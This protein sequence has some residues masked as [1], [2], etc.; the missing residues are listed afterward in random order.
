VN[1]DVA[2]RARGLSKI[3]KIYRHPGDVL[4]ELLTRR[5]RHEEKAAL[6]DV[7]FELRRGEVVGILGRNGAGKSTLLKL[8]A[9]TLE[10][11][12]GNLD[13]NGRITAILELG[14]GFHPDYTGRENVHMG[15]LCLGMSRDEVARK[16]DSIVDFSELAD[17]IDQPFRTY[18]TGMQARLTFSTAIAVDPDILIVD[19][20]LSVGDAKFQMKCFGRISEL[21]QQRK[22]ILLVSHDL[23]TVTSFCDHAIVLEHGRVHAM[24]GVREMASVYQQLLWST[25]PPAAAPLPPAPVVAPAAT[26]TGGDERAETDVAHA[27][28]PGGAD[29]R[30]SNRYGDGSMHVESYEL[31]DDAGRPIRALRSGQSCTLTF[32]MRAERDLDDVSTGFAIKDRRGTVLFGVTNIS[33]NQAPARLRAG[34]TMT[35]RIALRMWLA[36]GDYFINLGAGHLGSS[37][38]CDFIEDATQFNVIGPGGIFTTAVVNLEPRFELSV[39]RSMNDEE[40]SA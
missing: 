21:R 8:I 37:I 40:C 23:N 4:L 6:T 20:A 18:S 19:E 11:T 17:V 24:G 15:G 33:Q 25:N 32:R 9:G 10:R 3:F 26:A 28:P 1:A 22:T 35:L 34:E 12:S 2:I 29:A 27:L 13:I 36:A 31:I 38:M 39:C 30:V 14:T 5:T 16:F 7:S